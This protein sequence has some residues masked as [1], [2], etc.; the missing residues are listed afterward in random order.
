M[1]VTMCMYVHV[2]Y[3]RACIFQYAFPPDMPVRFSWRKTCLRCCPPPSHDKSIFA[4]WS[5]YV[6][7][8]IACMRMY[9]MYLSVL[10]ELILY[11]LLLQRQAQESP[12]RPLMT[13]SCGGTR[14]A[15]LRAP[16]VMGANNF[17]LHPC[18]LRQPD[19]PSLS[20]LTTRFRAPPPPPPSE[21]PESPPPARLDKK[22]G[23]IRACR[24]GPKP[25]PSLLGKFRRF[26]RHTVS[27]AAPQRPLPTVIGAC[28]YVPV[29]ACIACIACI[30]MYLY[31]LSECV[32][33]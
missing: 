33:I 14:Q 31:V 3:V 9:R 19:P 5:M 8:C 18:P 1:R 13:V 12:Q 29:C 27:A 6:C 25:R 28:M 20:P 26:L 10:Y 30:C 22:P 2:L 11:L 4:G 15:S 7:V 32:C 24:P 17:F 21:V 16:Q 23:Q